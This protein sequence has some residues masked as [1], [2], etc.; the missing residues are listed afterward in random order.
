MRLEKCG[1]IFIEKGNF[2][3]VF[4]LGKLTFSLLD[5]SSLGNVQF[6]CKMVVERKTIPIRG[7][8]KIR[9]IGR[10]IHRQNLHFTL[11]VRSDFLG[12]NFRVFCCYCLERTI[13]SHHSNHCHGD[14]MLFHL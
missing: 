5:K 12:L 2:L 6:I 14:Q 10:N 11:G 13:A 1:W 4:F 8:H 9:I 3:Q 7:S